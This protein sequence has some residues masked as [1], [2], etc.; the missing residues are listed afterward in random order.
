MKKILFLF[1]L[2]LMVQIASPISFNLEFTFYKNNTAKIDLIEISEL[3]PSSFHEFVPGP[4]RIALISKSGEILWE[5]NTEIEMI[6]FD[7]IGLKEPYVYESREFFWRLPYMAEAE[8]IRFSY[9]NEIIFEVNLPEEFCKDRD[10]LC[11]EFCKDKGDLDC[12]KCGDGICSLEINENY[13]NCEQDCPSGSKDNFCDKVKDK[14]CD[15]DCTEKEDVDC[16]IEAGAGNLIYY[17]IGLA[18]LIFFLILV[19]VFLKSGRP[20]P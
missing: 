6:V 10:A 12:L 1:A 2:I 14:I 7:E 8:K 16:F 11:P 13:K 19:F 18:A 4:Y 3:P 15:P 17:L 5:K 9:G 20:S